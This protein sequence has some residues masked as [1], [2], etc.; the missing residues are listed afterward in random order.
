[1]KYLTGS[2][3][4]LGMGL[5]SGLTDY[6]KEEFESFVFLHGFPE[7]ISSVFTRVLAGLSVS[8]DASLFQSAPNPSG[9]GGEMAMVD[10][11]CHPCYG[12]A[13]AVGL[14]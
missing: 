13:C 4:P 1:M 3:W 7:A 14:I 5:L 12:T 8:T 6:F 2:P 11:R 10:P 9:S